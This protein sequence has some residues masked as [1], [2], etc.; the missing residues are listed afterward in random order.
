MHPSSRSRSRTERGLLEQKLRLRIRTPAA[1][2]QFH[3]VRG[4]RNPRGDELLVYTIAS[5]PHMPPAPVRWWLKRDGRSWRICDW[6]RID[7]G[8]SEA[9]RWALAGAGLTTA[10]LDAFQK[11]AD[12]VRGAEQLITSG[13][14]ALAARDLLKAQAATPPPEVH[15][16]LQIE[17]ASAWEQCGRSD[18]VLAACARVRDL[19]A[20]PGVHYL[21]AL[22]YAR[23]EDFQ[24]TVAEAALY[25]AAA[26]RHP[27]LLEVEADALEALGRR[28]DAAD[29]WWQR[30]ALLPEDS[31]ALTEYC[32]LAGAAA[33]ARATSVFRRAR[34]AEESALQAGRLA[35]Y[36]DDDATVNVVE[37]FFRDVDQESPALEL[38]AG[39]RLE[40]RGEHL[41]AAQH[42][43][44]AAERAPNPDERQ[45]HYA[46]FLNAMAY[47]GRSAEGYL[48]ASDPEQ[49]L[50]LLTAGLEF[51][52]APITPDDLPRLVTL[53]KQ[54]RP[55][56]HRLPYLEGLVAFDAGDFAAAESKLQ[57]ALAKLGSA[58]AEDAPE[59]EE[60]C[61]SK[62]QEARYR[63]GRLAAAY[64]AATGHQ[65]E[66]FR[67]LARLC[68]A[69]RNWAAF[70][71]LIELHRQRPK[72][73]PWIDYF[74]AL[75]AQAE[76]DA[77]AALAAVQRAE[78][79]AD[80]GL[81]QTLA[82][83]KNQ[84]LIQSG[85][86][87]QAYQGSSDPREAFRRLVA[88][89]A[90]EEDWA[91][92][93]ELSELHS[94]PAPRRSTT[95]YWSAAANWRLG[96]YQAIIDSLTPWPEDRVGR[97][98][99]GQLTE[100]C[101]LVVRSHLRLG[102]LKQAQV[103]ADRARD[104]YGV[105]P[106]LL[107]LKLAQQ[108]RAAVLEMIEHPR[109]AR[110]LFGKQL[111]RDPDLA[112]LA[113]DEELAAVR[114]RQAVPMP[115]DRGPGNV[116]LVLFFAE[117]ITTKQIE[118][119]LA[120]AGASSAAVRLDDWQGRQSLVWDRGPEALVLTIEGG[121]YCSCDALP[122]SLAAGDPRRVVG[123]R[124]AR[125]LGSARF[126]PGR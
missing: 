80:D 16:V 117:P 6:Q 55:Q 73:D 37:R 108:D 2:S 27:H 106:P 74:L 22:A 109:I 1:W 77:A 3:L 49:A 76:G 58:P 66:A 105:E 81:K 60:L 45:A 94:A 9:A 35:I 44:L 88:H 23:R 13:H 113:T 71:E 31:N 43:R 69:D 50:A 36:R 123:C 41:A 121:A 11:A 75:R 24:N 15:D 93:L 114:R 34:V 92:V 122:E 29:C 48:A 21:R 51:G 85:G 42:F 84:L 53:H 32:R 99:A 67:E 83:L 107:A 68:Q 111:Y 125:R 62:L 52:E 8:V 46:R 86:I 120:S 4:E 64:Q 100:L 82:W 95:L 101:D 97:L 19:P 10:E 110:A 91:G 7:R 59:L 14:L 103:A 33:A 17:L 72:H 126:A 89:L 30:L 79:N 38:L 40:Q 57:G 70:D 61:R 102:Q 26:G 54:R 104:E 98:D 115:S 18:Q 118:Q 25:R 65:A 124:A 12:A 90:A 47:A 56:D 78:A 116:A 87:A 28:Q 5:A 96:R 39:L 63:Q 119:C 20:H 112:P